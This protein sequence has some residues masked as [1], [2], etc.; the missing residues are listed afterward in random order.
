MSDWRARASS[1][2]HPML[3]ITPNHI[4]L[5]YAA[6]RPSSCTSCMLSPSYMSL[7]LPQSCS[8]C[9]RL[10]CCVGRTCV[11]ISYCFSLCPSPLVERCMHGVVDCLN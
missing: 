7:S 10:P 5:C 1:V 9:L 6:C 2:Y 3:P 8:S 4:A 11:L